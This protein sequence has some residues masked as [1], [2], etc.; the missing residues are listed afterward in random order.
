MAREKTKI[1]RIENTTARQ[2]TFSKRR[3]GL[4]K[5][6]HELAVL[7][8]ASVGLLVFSE[9]CKLYEFSSASCVEDIFVKYKEHPNNAEKDSDAD[10]DVT[11]FESAIADDRNLISN[12]SGVVPEEL[13]STELESIEG[14]LQSG[15]CR[16]K[17]LMEQIAKLQAKTKNLMEENKKLKQEAEILTSGSGGQTDAEPNAPEDGGIFDVSLRLGYF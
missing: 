9:S 1:R 5:K 10:I 12:L 15:L 14:I 4:F 17:I 7:C 3:R 2:V 6:A 16:E 11:R 8:G 13:T